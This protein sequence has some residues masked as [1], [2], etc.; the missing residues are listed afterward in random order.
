M[1]LTGIYLPLSFRRVFKLGCGHLR[2]LWSRVHIHPALQQCDRSVVCYCTR[3][4][5][6]LNL[7][8]EAVLGQTAHIW[9]IRYLAHYRDSAIRRIEAASC[10]IFMVVISMLFFFFFFFKSTTQT[11]FRNSA[12]FWIPCR[13]TAILSTIVTADAM[14]EFLINVNSAWLPSGPQMSVRLFNLR[15]SRP[16]GLYIVI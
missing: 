3:C 2:S 1:F 11:L 8:G 14:P 13:N 10:C 9:K 5:E 12:R 16:R 7:A 15:I 4:R 6:G